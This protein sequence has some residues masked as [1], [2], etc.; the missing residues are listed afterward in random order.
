MVRGGGWGGNPVVSQRYS[1]TTLYVCTCASAVTPPLLCM[2]L[3]VPFACCVVSMLCSL[4]P[5]GLRYLEA[6]FAALI[7]V[8]CGMFG[9]MVCV[10]V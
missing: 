7:A 9:W 10:C 5:P 3:Y 4:S 6:F 2:L 1:E 8:M